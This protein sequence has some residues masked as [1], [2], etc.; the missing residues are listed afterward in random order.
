MIPQCGNH[1]VIDLLIGS[2]RNQPKPDK[3]FGRVVSDNCDMCDVG[4]RMVV[5]SSFNEL[6]ST[7]AVH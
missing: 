1:S 4:L 5:S 7:K 6:G 3:G 2:D